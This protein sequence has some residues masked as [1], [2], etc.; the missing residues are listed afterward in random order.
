MSD[1]MAA[2]PRVCVVVGLLISAIYVSRPMPEE[3]PE[4]IDRGGVEAW[5]AENVADVALPL[6][7]ERISGGRS[8]LTYSVTDAA[9]RRRGRPRPPPRDGLISPHD[10][11]PER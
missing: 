5:F 1:S 4:G 9:G 2:R 11:P 8:N 6:A 10:V 7:F 3:A